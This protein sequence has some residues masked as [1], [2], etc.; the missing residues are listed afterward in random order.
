LNRRRFLLGAGTVAA[1]VAVAPSVLLEAQ[2]VP[3]GVW[4]QLTPAD[5]ERDFAEMLASTVNPIEWPTYEQVLA[6][7]IASWRELYPDSGLSP[8]T[9]DF[10]FI[11]AMSA[12]FFQD[13]E[14]ARAMYEAVKS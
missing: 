5:I 10:Q 12:V 8:D 6:R 1:A 14:E 9:A 3:V 2:T 11:S 13:S 4:R 7:M